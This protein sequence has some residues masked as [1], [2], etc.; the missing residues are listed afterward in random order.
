M[1]PNRDRAEHVERG[2]SRILS[3]YFSGP[4]A[5]ACLVAVVVILIAAAGFLVAR[6]WRASADEK[7]WSAVAAAGETGPREPTPAIAN[8]EKAWRPGRAWSW[9]GVASPA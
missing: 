7:A 8:S 3:D 9:S 2:L 1:K 4:A 6:S 5:K